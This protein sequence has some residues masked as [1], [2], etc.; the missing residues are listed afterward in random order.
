VLSLTAGLP[1]RPGSPSPLAGITMYLMKESF[2]SILTKS[3]IRAAPGRSV[4]ESWGAA[5]NQ[6]A[7]ECA[8]AINATA[9]YITNKVQFDVYGRASFPRGSPATNHV[10]GWTLYNGHHLA[11]DLQVHLKPG[12]NTIVLDQR[13]AITLQ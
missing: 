8:Q 13:N 12:A 7:P 4:I 3:G 9:A 2:A 5:C 6:H 11:W 1:T 10:F